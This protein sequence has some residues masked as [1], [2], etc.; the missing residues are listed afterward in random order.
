MCPQKDSMAKLGAE[1]SPGSYSLTIR[2]K[3]LLRR[4]GCRRWLSLSLV[5]LLLHVEPFAVPGQLRD[6]HSGNQR[7]PARVVALNVHD[8]NVA[9][10]VDKFI[11]LR[12]FF[13]NMVWG[14]E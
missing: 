8:E 12:T 3:A 5:C 14:Q 11:I 7:H 9:L 10:N 1:N 2:A 13:R 6:G 4:S